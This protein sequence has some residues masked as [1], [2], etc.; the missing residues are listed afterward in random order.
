[1]TGGPHRE[2]P[3]TD[4]RSLRTER[5]R[6]LL[7]V[8]A[9]CVFA[10]A[11]FEAPA[12]FNIVNYGTLIGREFPLW[13]SGNATDPELLHIHR[14]YSHLRGSTLG[15]N[16]VMEYRVP[17][18]DLTQY[19]WDAAYDLHGFRNRSDLQRAGT[20]VI[21]DSFVEAMTVPDEAMMTSRLA[22]LQGDVVANLGQS[23]YG[24]Q[25]ESLVLK[26]W[27]LALQPRTVIWMFYEGNDLSDLLRYDA[28]VHHPPSFW[29][30][31]LGRSFVNNL[32]RLLL[33]RLKPSGER[34]SGVLPARDGAAMK[35]YFAGMDATSSL[36]L[37]ATHLRAVEE[38]VGIVET[39]RSLAAAQS[40]RLVFVFIPDKFRVFRQVCQFPPQSMLF[41]REVSDLPDRLRRA[42]ESMPPGVGFLDLT[43]ALIASARAGGL[44]YYRDDSHWSEEGN[45]VAADAVYA[46]LSSNQADR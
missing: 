44:P 24:P 6:R 34:V 12:L 42:V 21:G 2:L 1:V 18:F 25:E 30:A 37:D 14:P 17:Q 31:Y 16:I 3:P 5:I 45:R 26:R 27:G 13:A 40:A 38:T 43:P 29:R 9:S 41:K 8:A 20:V 11:L 46:Y 39:A 10:L 36:R 32:R 28:I 23:G 15:G 7:L 22:R 35:V 33:S 19:Q 4:L